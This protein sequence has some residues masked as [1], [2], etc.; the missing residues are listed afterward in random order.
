MCTCAKKKYDGNESQRTK[1]VAE[2]SQPDLLDEWLLRFDSV[3][4]LLIFFV[5]FVVGFLVAI[6]FHRFSP[7]NRPYVSLI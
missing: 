4:C 5:V 6:R 7:W 3:C 1:T 2:E